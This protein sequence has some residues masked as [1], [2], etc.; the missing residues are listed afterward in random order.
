MTARY[1]DERA[2]VTT[3]VAVFVPAVLLF[4]GLVYEGGEHLSARRDA[5]NA[6]A[7]AARAGAQALDP[8]Q[9][10]FAGAGGPN[11]LSPGQARTNAVNHMDDVWGG[12]GCELRSVDVRNTAANAV[13]TVAVDC[14]VAVRLVPGL[15]GTA[16]GE[17][18]A[19]AEYG[20]AASA[21]ECDVAPPAPAVP[22]DPD[23]LG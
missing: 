23:F 19:C 1:R 22:A 14:D 8:D 12:T 7:G 21:G 3:F 15:S 5:Y 6:A 11:R 18:T 2:M 13:V 10:R 4:V 16:T 9:T 17:A 20:I